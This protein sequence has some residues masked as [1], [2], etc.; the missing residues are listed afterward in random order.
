MIKKY[1]VI[2]LAL[3]F[4][5]P[6]FA[7]ILMRQNF[8]SLDVTIP[9]PP[10]GWMVK[11]YNGDG[12]K[13]ATTTSHPYSS[14]NCIR[15]NY[16]RTAAARDWFFTGPL[17]LTANI[18]YTVG[19]FY[20]GSSP[21]F[22]EKL[23][24]WVCSTQD[25]IGKIGSAIYNNNIIN[26]V[27]QSDLADFSVASTGTYYLGF[28]CYS[29]ANMWN[30]RIDDITVYVDVH[31]VGV[32]TIYSPL[33]GSYT[34]GSVLTPK[35][36]VR[37]YGQNTGG[38]VVPVHCAF[39]RY[40]PSSPPETL[41]RCDTIIRVEICNPE[42]IYC[43]P[44]SP[45]LPCNHKFIAWTDLAT[46]QN[47]ANDKKERSFTVDFRDVRPTSITKPPATMKWC[48]ESIPTVIVK[49][50]GHQTESFWTF[51]KSTDTLSQLEYLDSIPVTNLA[52]GQ[53][54]T[55]TFKKWHFPVCNH[56]AY[57]WTALAGDENRHNDTISI[58][59]T[60]YLID[61]EV[62][63]IIA[64]DTVTACTPFSAWATIHNNG[65]HYVLESG[66]WVHAKIYD[67]LHVMI[68][69]ESS[70]VQ[71]P[72]AYCETLRV[73]FP[74]LH[75]PNPCR[76]TLEIYTAYPSDQVPANDLKSK[77]IYAK[78]I[79]AEITKII[80]PDTIRVCTTFTVSVKVHNAGYHN[81][82]PAGWWV[83][84]QIPN[85]DKARQGGQVDSVQ[86]PVPLMPCETATVTFQKHIYEPCNHIIHAWI[87]YPN[88]ANPLNDTM[89]KGIVAKWYDVEAVPPIVN[90]P[91]TVDFCTTI[92][93]K[94]VVHNNGVH[95][96]TQTGWVI[97]T[98][99]RSRDGNNYYPV[100]IDSVQK[101]LTYCVYDTVTFAYHPDSACWH[102]VSAYVRFN[103]DQNLNN[104]F[105]TKNFVVR[106]IDM[107]AVTIVGIP[108]TAQVCNWYNPGV[109][110]HNNGTHTGARSAT[111]FLQVYRNG[112]PFGPILQGASKLL[113]PCQYDTVR[114]EWHAD[115]AC[116]HTIKAWITPPDQ[117][118][119]NDSVWRNFVVK[120]YDFGVYAILDVPDTLT[121]CTTINP[122]V[123]IHNN[124]IHTFA[125]NGWVYLKD[126]R[127]QVLMWQ[128]SVPVSGSVPCHWDTLTFTY[129]PDTCNH[130]LV[131]SIKFVPDQNAANDMITK[132]Y[133]VKYSDFGVVAISNVPDT[134]Q[135]CTTLNPWIVI[136]NNGV[137][138][139]AESC[140]VY[141][142]FY[143]NSV[144]MY[145]SNAMV[146]NSLPGKLDTVRFS[147]HPDSS[148]NWYLKA[149]LAC[150]NDQ[151]R[152]NDTMYRYF[153]VKYSDIGAV[154]IIDVPDTLQFCTTIYPKVVIH[155]NGVHTRAQNGWVYLKDYRNQVLMWQESVPV[156]GSVPCHWDTLTFTYHP[157]TCNH[158]LIANVKFVDD[159]NPA[160]DTVKKNYT[161][162]YYDFGAYAVLNIPDTVD[163]CNT[164]N[165][166]VVIHNNGVHTFAQ[167][168][169]VFINYYRDEGITKGVPVGPMLVKRDSQYVT[170]S[171]PCHWDTITFSWHPDS[172]CN[173]SA[174]AWVRFLPDQNPANDT[175]PVR[176][177]V[178]RLYDFEVVAIHGMPANDTAQV[179]NTYYPW[180]IV[181]NNGKHTGP[182]NATVSLRIY[183]NSNLIYSAAGS[184][185][186]LEPCHLDSFQFQW[187]ADSGC[188]HTLIAKVTAPIDQNHSNDSMIKNFVVKYYDIGAYAILGLPS[189]DTI[190]LCNT[191][192]PK[193]VIHNNGIHTFP[194][195][196]WVHLTDYRNNL[197]VYNES[198]FVTGT[199]PCHWDTIAFPSY[200]PD[201]CNHQ[202]VAWVKFI[203]DQNTLNDTVKRSYV[204]KYNDIEAYAIIIPADTVRSCSTY[205]PTVVVK[206]NGSHVPSQICTLNLKIWRYKIKLDS[207]CHISPDTTQ[208]IL[209]YDSSIVVTALAGSNTFTFPP[210]H[211]LWSDYYL[212]GQHHRI[213]LWVHTALDQDT[214]NNHYQKN[215]VV[216]ARKYDLQVNYIGLLR[217]VEVVN[218][219]TISVGVSYNP[220]SVVS[221]SPYGPT[222]S[223]R[224]WYKVIRMLTGTVVYSRYLDKTLAAGQYACLYYYSGWVPSDSGMY[225]VTS[226]LET[227]P[228]VDSIVANNQ[229]ERLFYARLSTPKLDNNA[230]NN[231]QG[232]NANLPKVFA[233]AQ[234]YPNPI[235][236]TT[237]IKWQI[238][239]TA[240]VKISVYDA[241]GRIIKTLTN[242][243][244]T[245]G[246]YN[247]IWN[248]T[249]DNSRNVSAGIYFYEMQANEF[250]AR[251][252]MVIAR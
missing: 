143:R 156:T 203:P 80:A 31:D 103:P 61:A 218:G 165:P 230:N 27:Y 79:D 9:N 23:K 33:S 252:K 131:A 176:N 68:D 197:L 146:R 234:N 84:C 192:Y 251:Y 86:V 134:I 25:S 32:D 26:T 132:N 151:N 242:N 15:Y 196:G 243:E 240:K 178:V 114:F 92:Y 12:K 142:E 62:K 160:N 246:Y 214:S 226:Y 138:T 65:P 233:M 87:H 119:T 2:L 231:A 236:A 173:H 60:V 161:V 182:Q 13:W 184:V 204:V 237:T 159:Q 145:N 164:I 7:D 133:T 73:Y 220:V 174:K 140:R 128:E 46:D 43:S 189:S 126:Y 193:V 155:N 205:T 130:Q 191:L 111:V 185:N 118:P 141:Y 71:V 170:N 245:P 24:V 78:R 116:N 90:V 11:D 199:Y 217:G 127:N 56:I 215:F 238:P 123:V 201:T 137:H 20:R 29:P 216:K 154:A 49:N 200:H 115:S 100:L 4:M 139:R 172:A 213:L 188:F 82:L 106:K 235:F 48:T 158:Q 81:I 171:V 85:L 75:I 219:D 247:S 83:Y 232:D 58:R 6:L 1:T 162:K 136:R 14:P 147:Y 248:C 179:C 36:L 163:F 44:W 152:S 120:Y 17:T 107:E 144:L 50:E 167:S 121:F 221:N 175:A 207:L 149:Y 249:D 169:W 222:A 229:L 210:W 187:H 28:E 37:N 64:P 55:L 39:V 250:H 63:W 77:T 95:V 54:T 5:L 157:D 53:Q 224:A 166:K 105:V 21:S 239:T 40:P 51:F 125:Q 109:V 89:S 91:D 102:T 76:H 8:D 74:N 181:H 113:M 72:L 45:Q 69:N 198:T 104:N 244:Y 112:L 101:T 190:Q 57:A 47:H 10:T 22:P 135:L 66:W 30:L 59:Y 98:I 180:V 223:F 129:H 108:D 70:Y 99:L 117:D 153:V 183:R 206:N 42:T 34:F 88:D 122:K 96:P 35:F 168:G 110:V 150:P 67:S 225:K 16:S 52:A 194:Q 209:I 94:I 227:R 186:N 93:P 97:Y 3:G 18:P 195:D 148:C 124:G 241:T 228:G 38:E 211:P 177:F 208:S 19:F 41:Y 212:V 202:F